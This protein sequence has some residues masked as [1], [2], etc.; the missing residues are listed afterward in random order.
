MEKHFAGLAFCPPPLNFR[1]YAE[2]PIIGTEL[3]PVPELLSEHV[4]IVKLP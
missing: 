2:K 1:A 3:L 4:L